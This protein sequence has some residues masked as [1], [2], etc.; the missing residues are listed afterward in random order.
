MAAIRERLL[1]ACL[2]VAES[3]WAGVLA[4]MLG[5][6][7]GRRQGVLTWPGVL[8]ILGMGAL[9][10]RVVA[11]GEQREWRFLL[12]ALLGAGTVYGVTAWHHGGLAWPWRLGGAAG[13]L[14]ATRTGFTLLGAILLWWRGASLA[15][16]VSAWEALAL[17]FRIGLG[18]LALGALVE[19]MGRRPLGVEWAV[20]PFVGAS[21][22]GLALAHL[23]PAQWSRWGRTLAVL[24]GGILAVGL[25]SAVGIVTP[26]SAVALRL[27]E[28]LGLLAR[29]LI[30]AV[31]VPLAYILAF[32]VRGVLS[33]LRWL[34]GEAQ[35]AQPQPPT[36]NFLEGLQ[37]QAREGS[38]IPAGVISGVKWGL[39]ALACVV[40]L[41]LL[42]RV[43][44]ARRRPLATQPEGVHEAIVEEAPEDPLAFLR[45]HL[46]LRGRARAAPPGPALLTPP[47]GDSPGERV[48]RAYFR[49]LN[50]AALAGASRPLWK[51]PWEYLPDMER[52]FP[53][54]PVRALTE[55]F[56]RLHYGGY[57]PEPREAVQWEAAVDRALSGSS[58]PHARGR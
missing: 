56:V 13:P 47:Q 14:E 52:L 26:L 25:V 6:I 32:L 2:L 20:V 1:L 12:G 11:Q 27:L 38:G 3:A 45:A 19:T 53:Q 58:A 39:V 51:T 17:G 49:L 35:P 24:V 28:G 50:S 29:W 40:A 54:A 41:Y 31:V 5:D 22:T 34:L 33:L 4:T 43:L 23:T 37:R 55:A 8:A 30:L 44:W 9:T 48:R 46:A 36:L 42:G 16:L 7:L 15:S 18:V 57:E 21:L 10:S